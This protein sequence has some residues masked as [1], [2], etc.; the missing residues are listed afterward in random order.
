MH[1]PEPAKRRRST[2]LR[3]A[4]ALFAA[5]VA[6]GALPRTAAAF[7]CF[8]FSMGAD[9]PAFRFG[10]GEPGVF[11]VWQIGPPGYP[12]TSYAVPWPNAP[13]GAWAP[14]PQ[15]MVARPH[16]PLTAGPIWRHPA[17]GA[18]WFGPHDDPRLRAPWGAAAPW[19]GAGWP[20]SAG[21][22]APWGG[23]TPW[24]AVP[25]GAVP[26]GA[27][28]WGAVPWGD[29]QSNAADGTEQ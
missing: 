19:P 5:A 4:L 16:G 26:W 10:V 21:G 27:V 1:S 18:P 29:G 15:F 2:L 25:W 12:P 13:H 28:P 24:G 7:V 22:G 11:R 20:G 9:G 8:G 6:L 14:P 23:G 3:P 17:T